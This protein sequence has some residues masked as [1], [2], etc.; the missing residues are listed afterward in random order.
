L[1]A[2]EIGPLDLTCTPSR[3]AYGAM[4]RT[5]ARY[6]WLGAPLPSA[7]EAESATSMGER[8]PSGELRL[9][10]R[11]A[12]AASRWRETAHWLREGNRLLEGL[13]AFVEG[14][15][16]DTTPLVQ[17][18]SV[19][20][21]LADSAESA[22]CAATQRS[23][24]IAPSLHALSA[25]LADAI[26]KTDQATAATVAYYITWTGARLSHLWSP[27]W[28]HEYSRPLGRTCNCGCEI[29]AHYRRHPIVDLVRAELSCPACSLIG[30]VAAIADGVLVAQASMLNRQPWRGGELQWNVTDF[31]PHR[32]SGGAACAS[33]FDPYRRRR[34]IGPAHALEPRHD[35]RLSQTIPS[36]WPE[37]MS[38]ATLALLSGGSVSLFVFEVN[39]VGTPQPAQ[40]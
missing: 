30:D 37:G 19:R 36:D 6:V 3:W 13:R 39:V 15:V 32:G 38:W 31:A 21:T 22:A 28:R 16:E 34:L 4:D 12:R 8:P 27:P 1:P 7:P 23:L 9:F 18:A 5:G 40:V 35:L 29:V 26:D 10:P 14:R 11:D 25:P 2:G 20:A 33:L 24:E 17:L